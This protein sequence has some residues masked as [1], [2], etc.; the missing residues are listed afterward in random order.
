MKIKVRIHTKTSKEEVK[1]IDGVNYEVWVKE[2]PVDNKANMQIMKM[3]KKYFGSP[4]K[5]VSGLTSRNKIVE[6]GV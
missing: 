1:K 5:I 6:V 3:L 2:K 4:V